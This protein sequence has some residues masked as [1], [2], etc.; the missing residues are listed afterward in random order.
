M[1]GQG[2]LILWLAIA[3]FSAICTVIFILLGVLML[4]S[5]PSSEPGRITARLQR[6]RSLGSTALWVLIVVVVAVPLARLL[7]LQNTT[8]VADLTIKVSGNL[9][10]WTYSYPD[11][12]NFSFDVPMLSNESA[13]RASFAGRRGR[14][15][16]LVVPV[17]ATIRIVSTGTKLFYS[18]T[19]P[20]LGARLSA[21]PGLTNES[22]FRADTEGVYYGRP[23]ELCAVLHTFTPVEIEVVSRE[24]FE[25]WAADANERLASASPGPRVVT[26]AP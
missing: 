12:G 18:W 7:Y 21:V 8:R 15:D 20:S 3:T 11:R 13:E 23:T 17:G 22:W 9:W 5:R 24:R 10:Y 25:R 6:P 16:H 2:S 19:I 4:R 14:G 26:A 1:I